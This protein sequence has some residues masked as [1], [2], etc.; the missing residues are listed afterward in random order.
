MVNN[1]G[2][3]GEQQRGMLQFAARGWLGNAGEEVPVVTSRT[4][5][6]A[7]KSRKSGVHAIQPLWRLEPFSKASFHHTQ[8][9]CAVYRQSSSGWND[10]LRYDRLCRM[11]CEGVK[12]LTGM[13]TSANGGGLGA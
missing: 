13:A 11:L 1:H 10:V 2:I 4:S 9:A 7:S 5:G 3:R 12:R 6:R 8:R